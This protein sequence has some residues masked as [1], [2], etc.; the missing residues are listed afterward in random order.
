MSIQISPRRRAKILTYIDQ[1]QWLANGKQATIKDLATVLGLLGN[2][3]HH[4]P[5]GTCHLLLFRDRL[6]SSIA[7]GYH[8]ARALVKRKIIP[9]DVNEW[10]QEIRR[11]FTWL[12]A[13][14]QARFLWR[15]KQKINIPAACQES[16]QPAIAY[17][18]A[19]GTCEPPIGHLIK[20][21]D[22]A[23]DGNTS[24]AS[25]SGIGVSIPALKTFCFVPYSHGLYLRTKLDKS[26]KDYV[27]INTL[28]YL[29]VLLV[30]IIV[31]DLHSTH[32]E[33][34]PPVP[35]LRTY[36]DNTSAIAWWMKASTKSTLG[37]RAVMASA[38]FRL[39]AQVGSTVAYIKGE[40]NVV[41]DTISRPHELFPHP[42]NPY[43]THS[44]PT[45]L[46]QVC[47]RQKHLASWTIFLPGAELHSLLVSTLSSDSKAALQRP[48]EKLGQYV[49]A[50]SI[51]SGGALSVDF[52]RRSF[53]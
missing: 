50:A 41:A 48:R 12:H 2:A 6:R 35:T 3:F 53:L 47:L 27:H 4:F 21:R 34:H 28:E 20:N 36:C 8:R 29:G 18:R 17:L 49:T 38:A 11:R 16:L 45:L 5:W 24:D 13:T 43:H 26:H 14:D 32:P 40:D 51:S 22:Y 7:A 42:N 19:G 46:A 10:P 30:S 37:R 33:Q 31:N 15:S 9:E 1:E 39:G 52:T 23:F 44:F 25:H